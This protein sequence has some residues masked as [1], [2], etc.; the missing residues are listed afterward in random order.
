MQTHL[1]LPLQEG[2][3]LDG[4]AIL[5]ASKGDI[6]GGGVGGAG[7]GTI[8]QDLREA[9]LQDFSESQWGDQRDKVA[10]EFDRRL[11]MLAVRSVQNDIAVN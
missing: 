1:C 8:L 9:Y 10:K 6:V 2:D 3:L 11:S 4:S 7:V 5:G